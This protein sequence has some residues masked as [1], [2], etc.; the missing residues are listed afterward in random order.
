[1]LLTGLM[2]LSLLVCFVVIVLLQSVRL[3]WAP[4]IFAGSFIV[5]FL[6]WLGFCFA[7]TRL[8]DM[9]SACTIPSAFYRWCADIN[10][11]FVMQFLRMDVT[12]VGEQL[13]PQEKFMLAGNHRSVFDPMLAMLFLSEY[14]MGFVAKKEVSNY[15]VVSRIMHKCFC[16]PLDHS[17]LKS[18]ARTISTA[19]SLISSDTASIGIYPEGAR[20]TAD[21]MLPFMAGAFRMAKKADCPIVVAAIKG[22]DK[23][24][25]NFL[26]FRR[27]A[28]T[29]EYIGVLDR[30]EVRSNSTLQLSDMTREMLE[31]ALT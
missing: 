26:T 4:V 8:V 17:S 15:P 11:E 23:V 14:N 13:L 7:V 24:M 20:N 16:L 19:A 27:T 1:M 31:Q 2:M 5:G 29:M 28:I 12:V 22:T 21:E 30:D 3:I 25:R 18:E 9:D 10:L 6:L